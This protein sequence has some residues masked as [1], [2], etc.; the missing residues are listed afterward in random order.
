MPREVVRSD[1]F[2]K[3]AMR[4]HGTAVFRLAIS[5]TG[6]RADAEDVYQDVFIA[7]ACCDTDFKDAGHL[8][9][10]L[11]RTTINRCRDLS[12]SW[13]RRRGSSLEALALDLPDKDAKDDATNYEVLWKA[14]RRLPERYRALVHL[15]YVEE[16]T[17]EQIA[18]ITGTNASTVRTRLS[19]AHQKLRALLEESNETI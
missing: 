16:M 11:L 1:A 9:A 10:W 8:K 15:R 3:A 5:Q 14:V 19:R 2:I 7:L 13:W 4:N 12:R 17:C 18:G 6:S